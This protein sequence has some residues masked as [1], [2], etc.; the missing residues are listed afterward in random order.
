[1]S[2]V[3][4]NRTLNM[5][6]IKCL[7]FDMDHTLV[8]YNSEAFETLAYNHILKKLVKEKDYP[9]AV[10]DFKFDFHSVIRG[11]VVDSKKGNLLKASRHGGIRVSRHGTKRIDFKKQQQEYRGTYVDLSDPQYVAI[12]T[13]FSLSVASLFGQLVDLKEE[14]QTDDMPDYSEILNDVIEVMDMSHRDDS[15]KSI[16]RKNLADYIIAEPKVT[17]GLERYKKHGKTLFIVTNSDYHYTKAL[18][19]FAITPYLKE[20]KCWSEL[21]DYVITGARKPRFFVDKQYYLKVNP[22]DGSMVNY[23]QKLEPGIYQGGNIKHLEKSLGVHGDEI[24]YVGDHIY[25]DVVRLKKDTQWRTALV[26]EELA[27]ELSNLQKANPLQL[28]IQELMKQK[29]PLEEEVAELS[30]K[31]IEASA[32]LGQTIKEKLDDINKIDQ[33]ISDLIIKIQ[34]IFNPQWGQIMRAG[35]EESYFAYQVD[36]FADIYTP[37]L[38]DFFDESPRKYYRAARRPLAHELALTMNIEFYSD[39]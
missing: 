4:V 27:E 31:D 10:L 22:E 11:L 19:D 13:A 30:S 28:E 39:H 18:L 29:S 2:K 12:D 26:I 32:G 8:R 6:K 35:M 7:G 34:A 15:L 3:F 37:T 17:E 16:V 24:F 23:D 1:M 21:F 38:A 9:N 33:K 20:H 14:R 36:R 5:K 25:G